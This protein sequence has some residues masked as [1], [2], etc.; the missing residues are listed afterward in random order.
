MQPMTQ[1]FRLRALLV[2]GLLGLAALPA[3][4]ATLERLDLDAYRGKV[5]L[6][7]FWAS[8]CGPCKESFPWMQQMANDYADRGLVVIAVNV[9]H[10]R[11]LAEQFLRAHQ[12]RF[13][14]VF[15]PQGRL[16]ESF[17]VSGMPASFYIDRNG[18]LRYTHIGFRAGERA[19]AQR[20]IAGLLAETTVAGR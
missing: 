20:E 5:V 6:L 9:D 11:A 19:D 2:A 14:I 15:D 16:A 18:K 4:P 12:P 10:E 8:W 7:D 17:H 1:R 13:P 3:R